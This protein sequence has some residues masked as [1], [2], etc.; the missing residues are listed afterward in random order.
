[1]TRQQPLFFEALP[2]FL[3]KSR[4]FRSKGS[5]VISVKCESVTPLHGDV[6]LF[7][8]KA[9]NGLGRSENYFLPV[10]RA[11]GSRAK[12]IRRT[13][14]QAVIS[15]VVFRGKKVTLYDAACF[16]EFYSSLYGLIRANIKTGVISGK[17][18]G[19]MPAGCGRIRV[20]EEQHSNSC[21]AAGKCFVKF[22]RR[23]E[24]GL[25][26]EPQ[27]LLS[28]KSVK[29]LAPPLA[30]TV[31]RSRK[32]A[33]PCLVACA[34]GLVK[35]RMSA[36]EL[37]T[38]QAKRYA[39]GGRAEP[40]L[41]YSLGKRTAQLHLA[42]AKAF[43][44]S[45][46]TAAG[47][48]ASTVA[49]AKKLKP[50]IYG[51]SLRLIASAAKQAGAE[52]FSTIRLHGDLHLGQVLFD[53]RKFTFIDFEG[54]VNRPVME[55]YAKYPAMKDIAGMGRSFSY[56]VYAATGKKA[57]KSLEK[58]AREWYKYNIEAFI[59]GYLSQPG[60]KKLVPGKPET[61]KA[62]LDLYMLEK[63]FYE[64]DYELK[65]R[66]QWAW[67]PIAGLEYLTEGK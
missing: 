11:E 41:A 34:Q 44:K 67:I 29:K 22:Y 39:D 5:P 32:G 4:W 46:V 63:N 57:L 12:N 10:A 40:K 13:T 49:A 58:K 48:C 33:N 55:R 9:E 62:L 50:A 14:P 25:N 26:P 6:L 8:I 38:S 53:G 47:I 27:L 65:T 21:A 52:K 42:L 20:L 64:I 60:A 45:A 18:N 23:A 2:G 61:F 31:T 3:Q 36:W 56:A 37:F 16:P 35:S 30:G 24:A 43:G 28:L 59:D 17:K 1:M 19:A 15:T 51:K 54:E 7:E 66:P